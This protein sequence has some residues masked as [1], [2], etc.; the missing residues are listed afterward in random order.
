MNSVHSHSPRPVPNVFLAE[1]P[2]SQR[3][4]TP[5]RAPH[6]PRSPAKSCPP[7]SRVFHTPR[8]HTKACKPQFVSFKSE[9]K[10]RKCTK[11]VYKLYTLVHG[12]YVPARHT[13]VRMHHVNLISTVALVSPLYDE[14]SQKSYF[15]QVGREGGRKGGRKGQRWSYT[16]SIAVF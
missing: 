14:Q 3:K 2:F 10:A 1:T 6:P 16:C 11:D 13:L 12:L 4:R 7:A 15:E 8:N 9:K 5:F